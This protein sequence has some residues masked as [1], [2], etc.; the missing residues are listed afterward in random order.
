MTDISF[1]D[2]LKLAE[3]LPE[4]EQNKLIYKLRLKQEAHNPLPPSIGDTDPVHDRWYT[5]RGSEYVD[6][7]RNPTRDELLSGVD[8]LR[9][10]STR[11]ENCLLGKYANPNIPQ[12]S[13][14]EFHAQIHAVATEWEQELDEFDT[15]KS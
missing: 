8:A 1:D 6:N 11:A 5:Q 10:T 13:E 14:E 12:M 15:D 3:Q 4:N 9:Q 2:V 7:Y